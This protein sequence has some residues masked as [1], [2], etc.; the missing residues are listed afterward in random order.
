MKKSI[1][2]FAFGMAA[3]L[4][5][6][7]NGGSGGYTP[8][9]VTSVPVVTPKEGLDQNYIPIAEGKQ[10]TFVAET[11][12]NVVPDPT[13]PKLKPRQSHP[14]DEEVIYKISKVEKVAEGQQVTWEI[15]VGNQLSDRQVWLV[16]D[17][18]IYQVVVGLTPKKFTSPQPIVLFPIADHK[19]FEWH[20]SGALPDGTLGSN[21]V[22]SH[23]DGMQEVDT[24]MGRVQGLAI[25][26]D[27]NFA[28]TT[29]RGTGSSV[30][31]LSPGLGI[32]RFKQIVGQVV[33]RT[34]VSVSETLRLKSH[35]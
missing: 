31:W 34:A 13:N 21:I 33:N 4:M 24:E 22:K 8:K 29:G 30:I 11:V 25:T 26:S 3:L 14:P 2:G 1:E 19:T 20:G 7:C 35:S 6:G 12:K 5:V 16:N 9:P 28:T 32:V 17:S 23:V 27:L 18:G 15:R 10:W